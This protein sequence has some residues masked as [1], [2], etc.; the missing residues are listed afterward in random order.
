VA[1]SFF[2]GDERV[3]STAGQLQEGLLVERLLGETTSATVR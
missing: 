3:P 1:G 2:N